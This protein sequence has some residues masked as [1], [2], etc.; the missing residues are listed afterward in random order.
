MSNGLNFSKIISPEIINKIIRFNAELPEIDNINTSD[1]ISLGQVQE[2]FT[3]LK[4]V[5]DSGLSELSALCYKFVQFTEAIILDSADNKSEAISKLQ[6]ILTRLKSIS[7]TSDNTLIFSDIIAISDIDRFFKADVKTAQVSSP[8]MGILTVNS[9]E[10]VVVYNEF[11]S[12]S[13]DHIDNVE[14]DGAP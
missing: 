6:E 3:G 5:F 12:E 9:S 14:S 10:D 13:G 7:L 4:N 8:P 1:L 11:V 2:Y